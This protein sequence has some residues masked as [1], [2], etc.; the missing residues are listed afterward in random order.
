LTLAQPL[1]RAFPPASQLNPIPDSPP[2]S[3]SRASSASFKVTQPALSTNRPRNFSSSRLVP[4]VDIGLAIFPGLAGAG[5][6]TPG[7]DVLSESIH[8]YRF[9]LPPPSMRLT[10]VSVDR[11]C[12]S[13]VMSAEIP[14]REP[15]GAG[16]VEA[17]DAFQAGGAT[18]WAGPGSLSAVR[19]LLRDW[20][21][22]S[23]CR[24]E[25]AR[26]RRVGI[27]VE[28]EREV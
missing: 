24:S 22:S 20:N 2:P 1:Q 4:V 21:C 27:G 14:R 10:V 18:L 13:D 6:P 9:F 23:F 7:L 19:A 17:D 11:F 28:L 3:P 16:P 8:E 5:E 26:S 25:R 15:R 12:A